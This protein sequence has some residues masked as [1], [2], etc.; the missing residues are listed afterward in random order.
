MFDKWALYVHPKVSHYLQAHW[1]SGKVLCQGP[2]LAGCGQATLVFRPQMFDKWALY[3][4]PKVSHYLQAHWH[5]GK[6]LCQG[7]LLAGCGQATLLRGISRVCTE[8]MK[9]SRVCTGLMKWWMAGL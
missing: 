3:V 1:H 4:H 8:L 6:V 2:L 7:P 5:S 9:W